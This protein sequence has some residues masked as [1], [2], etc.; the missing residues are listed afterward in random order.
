MK[1]I[2]SKSEDAAMEADLRSRGWFSYKRAGYNFLYGKDLKDK[3]LFHHASGLP[4]YGF[5]YYG[6]A[7]EK[8]GWA[9][10]IYDVDEIPGLTTSRR[11]H[12]GNF[13]AFFNVLVA[14]WPLPPGPEA[15]V[16]ICDGKRM[17][18]PP[19]VK[20]IGPAVAPVLLGCPSPYPPNL[21]VENGRMLLWFRCMGR[22][23]GQR[24]LTA[25]LEA[26]LI[27]CATQVWHLLA[28]S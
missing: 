21:I 4:A 6:L 14:P 1:Y 16:T 23:E 10:F 9:T 8:D 22:P 28:G 13:V 27:P 25:D 24:Y 3:F 5:S 20:N 7:Y 26:A 11:R 17:L 18:N 2:L 12:D 15:W 19:R